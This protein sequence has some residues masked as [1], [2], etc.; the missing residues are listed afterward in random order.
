MFFVILE[1]I[2]KILGIT[3]PLL[4]AVA[5]LTLAERKVMA[6]MQ[7]RLG[8]NVWGFAGILQPFWD[9]LKLIV[10]EPILPSS[11]DQPL[12]IWAPL[13]TFIVSQIAWAAIPTGSVVC[14]LNL[15]ALYLL[16]VSSLGVYG[17]LLAGWSSN[18]K[19]AFLGCCRCRSND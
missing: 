13:L 1:C 18:S 3:V 8:P 16:A 6:S 12:F 10:K 11:A 7:R 15:G 4:L 19:Y 2:L 9:G 5:F 14:D 17:I